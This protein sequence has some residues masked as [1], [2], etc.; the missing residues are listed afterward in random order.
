VVPAFSGTI[1]L[2]QT[3]P[4]P[5]PAPTPSPVPPTRRPDGSQP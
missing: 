2:D 3:R 5:T 1:S 4:A